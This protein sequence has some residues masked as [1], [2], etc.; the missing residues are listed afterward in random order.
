ME[1][2]INAIESQ[3]VAENS[4]YCFAP[5][6]TNLAEGGLVAEAW[7]DTRKELLAGVLRR[8]FLR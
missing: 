6:T 2:L 1:T 4:G 3:A 7:L 5:C 8:H